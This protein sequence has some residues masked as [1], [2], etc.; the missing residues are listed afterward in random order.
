MRALSLLVPYLERGVVER[1]R[2][3][4][5]LSLL[6]HRLE[7]GCVGRARGRERERV[8]AAQARRSNIAAAGSARG[9]S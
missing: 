9:I 1:A 2:G 6:V 8:C 4:R 3:M 5:A 7:R